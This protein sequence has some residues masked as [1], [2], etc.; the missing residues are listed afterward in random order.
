MQ[1]NLN[2]GPADIEERILSLSDASKRQ[3]SG[4]PGVRV[5]SPLEG[6]GRS[7]LVTFTVGGRG[8]SHR[9]VD[10]MWD[11]HNIVCR[12]V[13]YPPAVRLSFSFF[14]TEEEVAKT[15]AAI[16]EIAKSP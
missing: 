4:V 2:A 9:V 1:F 6:P 15:T 3:L 7:G 16:G 14:N 10:R 8:A 13:S 5:T 12:Q 11:E